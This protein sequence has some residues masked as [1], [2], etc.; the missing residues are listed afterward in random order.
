MF[1]KNFEIIKNIKIKKFF[2]SKYVDKIKQASVSYQMYQKGLSVRYSIIK[3]N[4]F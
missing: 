1:K 4:Y 2:L 3:N